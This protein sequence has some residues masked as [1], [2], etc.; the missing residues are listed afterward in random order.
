MPEQCNESVNLQ[1][2]IVYCN[3]YKGI[4]LTNDYVDEITGDIQCGFQRNKQAS[5][6][7]GTLEFIRYLR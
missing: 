2:C 6:S 1:I 4:M 3:N 7:S 5:Y